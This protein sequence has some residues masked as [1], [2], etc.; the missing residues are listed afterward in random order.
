M[1]FDQDKRKVKKEQRIE[2]NRNFIIEKY[3]YFFEIKY[4]YNKN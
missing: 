1:D 2:D 4:Q 3:L